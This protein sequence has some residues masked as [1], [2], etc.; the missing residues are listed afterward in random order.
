M[1]TRVFSANISSKYHDPI[2]VTGSEIVGT[3]T[4]GRHLLVH[5]WRYI[6]YVM[7]VNLIALIKCLGLVGERAPKA[8]VGH[9]WSSREHHARDD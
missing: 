9:M 2:T 6:V 3:D 8:R 7:Y 4:D 5:A 1:N